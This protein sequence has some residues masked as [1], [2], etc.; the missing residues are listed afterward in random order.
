VKRF[1]LAAALALFSLVAFASVAVADDGTPMSCE[2]IASGAQFGQHV[3]MHAR[4]M[5]GFD[6]T[7]NPG[8]HMG[9]STLR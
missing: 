2:G 1:A 6:G 3:A 8:T 5:G 4:L 7:M 9:Y